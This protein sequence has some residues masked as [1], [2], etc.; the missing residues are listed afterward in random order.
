MNQK[1]KNN[2]AKP[3]LITST[4]S[5]KITRSTTKVPTT[6]VTTAPATTT[7]ILKSTTTS[8]TTTTSKYVQNGTCKC[9]TG[10][11]HFNVGTKNTCL[12]LEKN[13]DRIQTAVDACK[14]YNSKLPLPTN[15]I[16]NEKYRLAILSLGA[17]SR[18]VALDLNDIR[19]ENKFVRFSDGK[20]PSWYNW[21]PGEPNNSYGNE[22]YIAL[23]LT[24]TPK[25][26]ND[27]HGNEYASI[28]CEKSCL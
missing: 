17:T 16:E 12:K 5:S 3:N 24:R 4:T 21:N 1:K 18:G 14:P 25:N 8:T 19:Q 27:Y 6:I 13:R 28:V 23:Y 10:F 22:D 7:T 9:S 2:K 26:W 15:D 11:K 20:S